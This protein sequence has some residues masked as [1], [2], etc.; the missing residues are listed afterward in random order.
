MKTRY[1]IYKNKLERRHISVE[2]NTDISDSVLSAQQLKL[3]EQRKTFS[4]FPL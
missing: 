1:K 3:A 2:E 4:E